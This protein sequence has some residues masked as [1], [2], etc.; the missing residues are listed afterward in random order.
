MKFR[1]A[2]LIVGLAALAATSMAPAQAASQTRDYVGG[3]TV[4]GNGV[5]F[6]TP[7]EVPASIG[8]ASFDGNFGG[9]A[10][11][12]TVTDTSGRDVATNISFRGVSVPTDPTGELAGHTQCGKKGTYTAPAGTT[13]V[14]VFVQ[15]HD[16]DAGYDG[17]GTGKT[18][19]PTYGNIT[20]SY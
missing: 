8:G 19:P 4:K 10:V 11:T 20:I 7:K 3:S 2:S 13:R 12:V 15:W 6:N 14:V 9:K 17:C 16:N 1:I 5:T 18:F